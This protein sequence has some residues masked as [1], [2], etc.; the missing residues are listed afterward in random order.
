MRYLALATI[1]FASPAFAEPLTFIGSVHDT[2]YVSDD[3]P[4]PDCL[5]KVSVDGKSVCVNA[6]KVDIFAMDPKEAAEMVWRNLSFEVAKVE[7]FGNFPH[8]TCILMFAGD[9]TRLNKGP[10]EKVCIN[11]HSVS[12]D[13]VSPDDSA[14]LFYRELSTLMPEAK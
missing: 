11:Y 7:S 10:T 8:P 2:I 3:R 13:G 5:L 4:K 14:M 9:H 12:Y 6:G 1:L